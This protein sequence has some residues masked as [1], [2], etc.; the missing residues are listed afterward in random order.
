MWVGSVFAATP[1][2]AAPSFADQTVSK[3]TDDGYQLTVTKAQESLDS[4]PPLNQSRW[5]R[6]GF[7]ALKG[8]AEIGGHAG[9]PVTAGTVSTGVQIGCNTDVTSG[10]TLGMSISP[11][12]GL[13]VS[14]PPAG[15]VGLSASR[16]YRRHFDPAR[17]P[18]FR[19]APSL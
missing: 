17:S 2:D 9:V 12:V 3:T 15:N 16:R 11:S 14:W 4:V 19:W 6:E 13:T 8:I 10:I 5:T 1:A 7:L 18:T